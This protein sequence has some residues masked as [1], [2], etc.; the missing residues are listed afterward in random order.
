MYLSRSRYKKL[1]EKYLNRKHLT[2]VTTEYLM[3]IFQT[4]QNDHHFFIAF[5]L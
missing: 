1:G 4:N 3:T 2:I 5:I